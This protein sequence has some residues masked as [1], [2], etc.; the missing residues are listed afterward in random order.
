[1]TFP[2]N[3]GVNISFKI[4]EGHNYTKDEEIKMDGEIQE[5]L[6]KIKAVSLCCTL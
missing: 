5:L 1:L 4:H 2:V 3:I 6:R